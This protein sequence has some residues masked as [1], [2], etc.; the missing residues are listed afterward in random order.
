MEAYVDKGKSDMIVYG[1]IK[2][3]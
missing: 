1:R 3:T 2:W